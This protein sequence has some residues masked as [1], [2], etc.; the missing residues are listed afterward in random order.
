MLLQS[1]ALTK[2]DS[3]LFLL[4]LIIAFVPLSAV[5]SEIS[6]SVRLIFVSMILLSILFYIKKILLANWILNILTIILLVYPILRFSSD[7]FLIPSIEAVTIVL[8][9]RLLGKKTT[10]EYFQIYLIAVL[11]L[12]GSSLLNMGWIFLVRT[13]LMLVLTIISILI[14][15]YIRETNAQSI[16]IQELLNFAKI[17]S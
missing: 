4:S 14:L 8:S 9:I 5:Y 2:I 13:F 15:T 7:D 16:K 17:S 3:I 1:M 12:A 11:L 6:L 10:R